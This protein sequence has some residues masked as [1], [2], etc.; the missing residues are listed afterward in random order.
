[1]DEKVLECINEVS[2]ILGNH[3][4]EN[5]YQNALFS[6]LQLNS[7]VCQTEVIVPILYKNIYVGFE[8][9]DVVIYQNGNPFMIIELKSQNSRL[10]Y[11]E[12]NQI[13]KY[14]ANLNCEKGYLV[15]FYETLEI[16]RIS[17]TNHERL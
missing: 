1:M 11:K 16:Y 15:N 4:K 14:M 17:S 2:N 13:K 6:E 10:G 5:I 12:I 7:F 3:Y 8:R 9:A